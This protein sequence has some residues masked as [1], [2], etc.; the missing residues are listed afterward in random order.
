MDFKVAGDAKGISTFQLDIKCEGLTLEV[1][2]RALQQAK[3][4]R[5][6]ILGDMDRALDKP[7]A[8]KEN[9]PKILTMQG[10]FSS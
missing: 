9:I 8:M 4:G 7:R 6:S 1:L 2:D 10:K 5:L 3:R